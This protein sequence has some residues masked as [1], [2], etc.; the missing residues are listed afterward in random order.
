[1]K[2]SK[3]AF[4]MVELIF[5]IAILGILSAVAIPRFAATRDDAI[6]ANGIATIASVRAGIIT[7]RQARLIKGDPKWITK[8]N[9]DGGSGDYFGGVMMYGV[10]S[11]TTDGWSGTAGSGSYTYTVGSTSTIFSY[12]DDTGK[13]TCTSGAGKCDILSK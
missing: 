9:L 2:N 12:D 1:M 6:I 5:V 13:F 4:T 8:A 10:N 7:E 3:K 11:S